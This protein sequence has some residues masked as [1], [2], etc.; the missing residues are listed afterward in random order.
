MRKATLVAGVVAAA[1]VAMAF[2]GLLAA[3]TPSAAALTGKVTSQ[4]EGAMEGV[5]IGA[6]KAGSNIAT[7]VVSNAQGEYSFP[8][9]R[10]EPGKYSIRIRAVGY[11]LPSTSVDVTG[12]PSRLDLQLNK[13]TSATK[14]GM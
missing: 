6:K 5:L 1:L 3:Q 13:L 10:M 4:A 11:E 12:Q 8:R 14:V 7:W 2:V 9:D